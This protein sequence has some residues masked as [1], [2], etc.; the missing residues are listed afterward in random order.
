M[1]GPPGGA[2]APYPAT[3]PRPVSWWQKNWK[4]FVPV[5]CLGLLALF[6]S[7]VAVLVAVVFGA[8]RSTEPVQQGLAAARSHPIVQERL[9][10]PIEL[11]WWLS[12][13]VQVNGPNGTASLMLPLSGPKRSATLYIEG[14][15]RAGVWDFQVLDVEFEGD[16]NRL[17]LIGNEVRGDI[18]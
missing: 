5:G 13:G 17:H 11:G 12:G 10:T 9:G 3:A 14:T 18:L 1:I 2:P 15:K 4:W 16:P 7:F 6:A 8:L